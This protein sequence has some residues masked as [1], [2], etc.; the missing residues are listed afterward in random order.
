MMNVIFSKNGIQRQ[1]KVGFSWTVFFFG[2]FALAYRRQFG[3]AFLFLVLD[4]MLFWLPH[5]VY[6]FFANKHLAE[7]LATEG[8]TLDYDNQAVAKSAWGIS[9]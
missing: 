9:Q 7:Q 5:L 4:L 3:F 6:A 8:W 1:V 2:I